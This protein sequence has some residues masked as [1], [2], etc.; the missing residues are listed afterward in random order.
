M[1]QSRLMPLLL[2]VIVCMAMS[3]VV[4]LTT[5]SAIAQVAA[6]GD[7]VVRMANDPEAVQFVLTLAL[8]DPDGLQQTLRGMYDP[9]S[10]NFRHFLKP[11][12][13]DARYAPSEAAYGALKDFARSSGLRI[14]R[15]QP[16]HTLL[17]VSGDVA[18]IRQLFGVQM[19]WRQTTEGKLYLAGDR[20]PVPPSGLAVI[21]G[22]AAMLNQ[23]PPRP[24]IRHAPIA[25]APN[26][27]TGPTGPTS[28]DT[29][30][31]VPNDIKTAYDLNS[32]QNGGMPVAL[33][34]L[35]SA[36]YADAQT[37]AANFGLNNP[38]PTGS[39][40]QWLKN[41]DGGTADTSGA[42]EVMLDVDMVMAVSNPTTLYIY[43]APLSGWLDEYKQIAEDNLVGEVSSSWTNGCEAEV[44]ASTMSAE[45][46]VFAQMA[47]QGI[48]VFIAAGDQGSYP[49]TN[50]GYDCSGAG[51]QVTD[52]ASQPYITSAGG[53]TLTT[54]S[55]QAYVSETVWNDLATGEGATGGGVS[56]YWSIP[57]YQV[58]VAQSDTEFST[59]MRNTPDMSLNADPYTGYYIY[60][61]TFGGWIPNVGGTSAV[62]PQL[63]AFWSMVSKGLGSRPGFA[64]PILYAIG[65][66]STLYSSG[67]HDV[68]VGNNGCI[69][70][71]NQTCDYDAFTGY[72]NATGWGSYNGAN[73][74]SSA[75]AIKRAVTVMP[76]LDLLLQ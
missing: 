38:I 43:S 15:E 55:S 41:V 5:G 68:T 36:N 54:S 1:K 58:G 10:P 2:Q 22:S 14:V 30:S 28:G 73:L 44:G 69:P 42:D 60:C 31:Y 6:R 74:Y 13:F 33:F 20:E 24:L 50:G 45:N 63:A 16:G 61:S 26:T 17:D 11:A 57:W 53:T 34:E 32:I 9:K 39:E 46:T 70:N 25:P 71:G 49:G 62:A 76:I 12:E 66:N 64:N 48:A 47:A 4:T 40:S 8:K 65:R 59:T 7:K 35:S 19:Y 72:D 67:F 29:P 18:A 23:K 21:S 75:L 27:G 51:A 3:C 37:Y 52:P 56:S